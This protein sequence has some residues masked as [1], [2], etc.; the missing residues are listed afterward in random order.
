MQLEPAQ[1]RNLPDGDTG[2]QNILEGIFSLKTASPYAIGEWMDEQLTHGTLERTAG[3]WS[4]GM[5]YFG[6]C[7]Y[8]AL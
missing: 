8:L 2:I 5:A 7:Q 6:T 1:H 4:N 3:V